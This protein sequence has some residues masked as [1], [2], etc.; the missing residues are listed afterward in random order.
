MISFWDNIPKKRK[1]LEEVKISKATEVF[2]L[3]IK[4]LL[5]FKH[6]HS[7]HMPKIKTQETELTNNI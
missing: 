1:I 7:I 6:I 3:T 2:S 4:N 5:T